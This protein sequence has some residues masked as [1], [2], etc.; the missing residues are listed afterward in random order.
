MYCKQL[1]R[2][3][4]KLNL[5]TNNPAEAFTFNDAGGLEKSR[6]SALD[7]DEIKTVFEAFNEPSNQFSRENT[8]TAARLI[9]LGIRKGELI[10][11]K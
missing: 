8:L 4:I 1:F 3:G 11:A 7:I 6:S 2:H 9:T 10:A 5:L